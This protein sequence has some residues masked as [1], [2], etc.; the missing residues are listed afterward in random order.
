MS[1][2][3]EPPPSSTH[4]A[5]RIP[6]SPLSGATNADGR[7]Y[8]DNVKHLFDVHAA[9]GTL[10]SLNGPHY[11][12][13]YAPRRDYYARTQALFDTQK[14]QASIA[15]PGICPSNGPISL[16]GGSPVIRRSS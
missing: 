15:W 10:D 16:D 3:K 6:N 5:S 9:R 1:G 14:F 13:V 2:W 12:A 7:F 8:Y 4:V 11:V